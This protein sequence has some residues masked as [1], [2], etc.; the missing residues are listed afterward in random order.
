M[1]LLTH[2]AGTS[3]CHQSLTSRLET[4]KRKD[5]KVIETFHL[6]TRD[7]LRNSMNQMVMLVVNVTTFLLL[8]T[9][10]EA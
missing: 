7:M 4:A 1:L 5:K 2:Q 8:L 6:L 10:S 9:A 3:S